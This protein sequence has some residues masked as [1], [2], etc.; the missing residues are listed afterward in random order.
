MTFH[1]AE[2]FVSGQGAYYDYLPIFVDLERVKKWKKL[3]AYILPVVPSRS[4]GRRR[5]VRRVEPALTRLPQ[6]PRTGAA[7]SVRRVGLDPLQPILV[8]LTVL[9]L[10]LSPLLHLRPP[11][12]TGQSAGQGRFVRGG[13]GRLD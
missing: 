11:P 1:F 2:L 10:L 3:I 7:P 8:L 5:G 12:W 4:H 6:L 9:L 13:G